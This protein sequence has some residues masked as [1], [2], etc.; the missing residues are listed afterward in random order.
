MQVILYTLYYRTTPPPLL[1][2]A[3]LGNSPHIV[4][5]INDQLSAHLSVSVV[6]Y[7][8]TRYNA[9]CT[10]YSFT[11]YSV[12]SYSVQCTVYKFTVYTVQYGVYTR[13]S[14]L[15][16]GVVRVRHGGS[17]CYQCTSGA[18][19]NILPWGHESQSKWQT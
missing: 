4:C 17:L 13:Q 1:S 14:H 12:H 3:T 18:L 19:L 8:C 15:W 7:A 11:L 2:R 16:T 10:G 9:Q 6:Q 5:Y